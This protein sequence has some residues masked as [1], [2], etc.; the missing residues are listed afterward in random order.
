MATAQ[1]EKEPTPEQALFAVGFEYY[2]DEDLDSSLF[3][4]RQFKNLYPSSSLIPRTEY[5]IGVILEEQ[6]NLTEAKK[7]FKRILKSN[8]NEFDPGG[9]GLMGSQYALYKHNSCEH[10]SD[11]YLEEKNYEEAEKYIRLFDKKYPYRHF[12][13]NELSAY[14]IFKAR[15][16]AK[17]YDGKGLTEKAIRKLLPFTFYNGLASNET[18]IGEL[19]A[20][21][22]KMYTTKQI[23][24]AMALAVASLKIKYSR[25]DEYADIELFG[26]K[27][28]VHDGILFDL[29]NQDFQTNIY[30]EGTEK[31][32][33]VMSTH[34][35]F[36]K[37]ST[38]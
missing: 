32:K 19:T 1:E 38:N 37:Y 27:V 10:L 17:V 30:L 24:Q 21:I 6:G 3:V 33:K 29:R 14:E 5:N 8:Y 4:F 31:Y 2:E 9:G 12:C 28:K 18:L 13:G 35:L 34:P 36:Q 16:Y 26:E 11:I 15:Y 23:N 20:L 7:V 25:R 22:E